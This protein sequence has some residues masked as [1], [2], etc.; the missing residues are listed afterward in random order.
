M[1]VIVLVGFMGAGKSTVGR[2]LAGHL[3]VPFV[4]T[5]LDIERRAGISIPTIFATS[6]EATF[7]ALEREAV[8]DA[9]GRGDAVVAVGGG[10]LGDPV[11]RAALEWTNV[12]YL[13][14][15]F[16]E[17]MRRIGGAGA[18]RPL[19]ARDPKALFDERRATYASAAD[20]TIDTD[21]RT[22][23]EIARAIAGRFG[24]STTNPQIVV[25]TDP[26]Y[27][28]TVGTHLLDRVATLA[29]A[30]VARRVGIITH[31]EIA[32]IAKE[33]AASYSAAGL[34][35]SVFEI[36]SGEAV[37]SLGS[38]GAVLS[39]LARVG[40]ERNDLVV[41]VGGGVVCDLSGFIASTYHRGIRCAYVPTTLLAQ[42]DASIGGK[43]AV[44]L[45][46]GKNLVGTFHQ[47]IAVVC[48]VAT[49][50]SLSDEEFVSGL[51]EVVK[52][53]FIQ[54]PTLLELVE[55]HTDKLRARDASILEEVVRRC[56]GIKAAIVA[57]DER[58]AGPRAVL[59]Y[60]HTIGH[61]L[62]AA[63]SG[64]LRHGEAVALGMVAA[65]LCALEMGY[66]DDQLV[67]RHRSVLERFGLPARIDTTLTEIEPYL[68]RDKK[69][70][71]GPRFVVLREVGRAEYGVEVPRDVIVR[72]LERLAA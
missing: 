36:P 18:E 31:P 6:G 71:G 65:A 48:D 57:V 56:V 69:A 33:V 63:R 25:G 62:E 41:G 44:D 16:M 52:Y 24:A 9:L 22:P 43:T 10:A 58:D 28:V 32:V 47:P 2:L 8:G 5:D 38:A 30:P 15:S 64:A 34:E 68:L 21:G 59:N 50:A 46:E 66:S 12:L 26:P 54:D 3:G 55:N 11:T 29:T 49:L 61:A 14:V 23:D 51:A 45:P 7:R 27:T 20:V 35:V 37:K 53:G 13:E 67:A 42:V 17:A 40:L 19:L 60:G 4:D 70:S 72:A 1:G 39:S